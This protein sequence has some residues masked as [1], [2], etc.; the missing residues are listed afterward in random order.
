MF[1]VSD[2]VLVRLSESRH[3]C[4]CHMQ[5]E[6]RISSHERRTQHLHERR[7]TD[8]LELLAGVRGMGMSTW[9]A[10]CTGHTPQ[11]DSPARIASLKS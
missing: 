7:V 10:D 1:D 6:K 4:D 9:S 3:K 8:T 2:S 5:K 11:R